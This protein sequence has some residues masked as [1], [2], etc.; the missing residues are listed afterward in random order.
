MYRDRSTGLQTE[1]SDRFSFKRIGRAA[2]K[3]ESGQVIVMAALSMTILL[4]FLAFVT[5]VGLLLRQ[6]RL[7]QTA[8]DSAAIAA[9]AELSNGIPA[10]RAAA[11][12]D[13][14]QNGVTN[15]SGGVTITV[16]NPPSSGPNASSTGK[17]LYA[18]VIISKPQQTF[19]MNAYHIGSLTVSARA[20]AKAVAANACLWALN[21]AAGKGVDIGGTTQLSLPNCGIID[22]AAG[23]TAL[24]VG[25]S[26]QL[27]AKFVDVAGTVSGSSNI[28]NT[29][30]VTTGMTAQS[31]PLA[32]KVSPPTNP[33]ACT[34]LNVT[35]SQTI[36]PTSGSSICYSS[37][38]VQSGATATLNP[39]IY[40]IN[41]SLSVSGGASLQGTGGVTFYI[42]NGGSVSITGGATMNLTAPTSGSLS[43]ILFYQD[44][45]DTQTF[46][47]AGGTAGTING[48]FYIPTA[49][50]NLNGGSGQTLNVDLV[51][52]NLNVTGNSFLNSYVPLTGASSLSDPVLTE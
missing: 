33:G 42:T 31:D 48:I 28:S 12:T 10:A 6:K 44:P 47:F 11:L 1:R 32:S 29:T 52:G 24:N 41:G 17:A 36:G 3:G 43:G 9:A 14:S 8:A 23:S 27:S 2:A 35:S 4:G 39:G 37:L 26:A 20:V 25:G 5:D 40:Y 45:A 30:S 13:A 51:V 50:L 38:S 7:I 19:F 49:Q 46:K 16:N 34:S 22:N 18:E 21:T 15:G